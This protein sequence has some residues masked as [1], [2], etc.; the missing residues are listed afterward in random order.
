MI[1]S[2]KVISIQLGLESESTFSFSIQTSIHFIYSFSS[3]TYGLW[4]DGDL[5]HGRTSSSKTFNNELLTSNEDFVIA[6]IE[7]W[8]F[9]D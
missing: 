4:L 5:Y 9:T 8:T 6:S 7:V 1:F 3:G 2:L